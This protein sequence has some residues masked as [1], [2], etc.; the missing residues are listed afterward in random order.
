MPPRKRSLK[1]D[2]SLPPAGGLSRVEREPNLVT[3][4]ERQLRDA[5]AA[6]R[7]AHGQLPTE[8]ELAEEMGVSRET[9]RRATET[10]AIEG[11]LVKFRRKG[12]FLTSQLPQ[13]ARPA[14]QARLIGFVQADYSLPDGG[15]E[16]TMRH[17]GRLLLDGAL[18]SAR[19]CHLE[20]VVQRA[21][22]GELMKRVMRLANALPLDGWL[23]A[24]LA[25]EKLVRRLAGRGVPMVLVDHDARLAGVSTL[26]DDS[27]GGAKLAVEHLAGLGHR[28]I[29]I[30]YWKAVDLNP[31]RLQGYRDALRA[32]GLPRKRE[33][34][35]LTE[36]GPAGAHEVVAS[37]RKLSPRPTAIYCFN[38]SLALDLLA[39]FR[40]S[41]IEV[42]AEVSV[43]G[44][45]G[46]DSHSLTYHQCDWY[47]MGRQAV[48]LL[49]AGAS[50][51]VT[52]RLL[53]HALVEG[54]TTGACS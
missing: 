44:G 15:S 54:T 31:W 4:V 3:R 49:A 29:A 14:Q 28:R 7:F 5:I 47:E 17:I 26:R 24:S 52:H 8:I 39:A 25:E 33:W 11:L 46:L 19:K 22:A 21:S 48:E 50:A 42:P 23:F 34:E 12:T 38:N 35:I 10:L 37:W 40:T 13:T 43:V 18:E 6:G 30:A 53:P 1:P 41:G 32:H 27:V 45:G 9:V 36:L 51:E 2:P 20:L 16:P